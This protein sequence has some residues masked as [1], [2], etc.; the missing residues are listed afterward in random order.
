M[1]VWQVQEAKT[2]LSE[3]IEEAHRVGPQ[4]V[5][6]HGTER[7]VLLSISEYRAPTSSADLR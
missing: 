4:I 7:A 6:R 2:R 5:T 3:M 1:A